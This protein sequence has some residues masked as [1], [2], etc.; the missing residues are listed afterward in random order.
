MYLLQLFAYILMIINH[1]FYVTSNYH[2]DL[3]SFIGLLSY[4]IFTSYIAYGFTKSSNRTLYFQRLLVFALISEV[5]WLYL[6]YNDGYSFLNILF[7]YACIIYYSINISSNR[8]FDRI[9]AL[10]VLLCSFIF[11]EYSFFTYFIFCIFVSVFN[12]ISIFTKNRNVPIKFRYLKYMLYPFHLYLL[13][14]IK[15]VF[16]R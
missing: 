9:I 4:I 2:T 16:L 1:F 15:C 10:L 12:H 6:F 7:S 14:L 11:C 8:L 5:P 3:L 13:A